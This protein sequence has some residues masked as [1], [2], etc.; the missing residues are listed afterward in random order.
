MFYQA[1][2]PDRVVPI[3]PLKRLGEVKEVGKAVTFLASD[4][5]SYTTGAVLVLDGG[6][7]AGRS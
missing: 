7:T 6:F 1:G 5:S 2:T 3:I 4:D